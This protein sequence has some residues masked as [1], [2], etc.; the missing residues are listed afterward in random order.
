MLTLTF[1]TVANATIYRVGPGETHTEIDTVPWE[2]LNPGDVVEIVWRATP[3]QSKWVIAR[4]G[5]ANSPII[6]RGIAN[7]DGLLPIVS[8][9]GAT[10][11]LALD[12]WNEDRGVI[13]IGGASV[14]SGPGRHL[15]IDSLEIR[16]AYANYS[17]T[18]DRGITSSY[19]D[20][21]AAIYIE[22][23]EEVLIANCI[24]TDSGNGLFVANQSSNITLES[25]Y[26][27]GNGNVGSIF[28]HNSY[29]EALGM[30]YQFNRFG[31]LRS[32]A[33]GNNLKDRSAGLIVRYN[34]IEDGNRQLDLVDSA[35]FAVEQEGAYRTTLVYGNIL[36]EHDGQGNRQMVHYGGDSGSTANYRKGKLHFYHNTLVSERVGRATLFRL[37][38]NDE[39]ADV[40]NN[41]FFNAGGPNTLELASTAGTYAFKN[42]WVRENY[43]ASFDAGFVGTITHEQTITG[44]EPGFSNRLGQD[45]RPAVGAPVENNATSLAAELSAEFAPSFEYRPHSQSSERNDPEPRDIGALQVRPTI[46]TERV[47][48]LP[49]VAMFCL[50][51]CLIFCKR[52]NTKV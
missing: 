11:R 25:S 51:M 22:H 2:A 17:F 24:L 16:G 44:N 48:I 47:P 31:P 3:Y 45:Y 5:T 36:L 6:V 49:K 27:Y 41:I 35:K 46:S 4:S 10:T 33:G 20:N 42:N 23:G 12:F 14:P 8:G 37:A 43:V 29:T 15:I 38:T 52:R 21:A 28:E 13:K 18:D 9:D 30:T 39:Q 50:G 26:V 19:R 1:S 40:R 7:S 34:W 32:G